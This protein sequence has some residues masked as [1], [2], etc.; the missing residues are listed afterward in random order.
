MRVVRALNNNAVSAVGADGREAVL[1]GPGIGFG[2][3]PG[4]KV[5][6]A[7]AEKVFFINTELQ[8]RL[9]ALL[10]D[11][12]PIHVEVT[13]A[14]VAHA[15][16]RGLSLKDQVLVSLADH[17][18]FAIERL[19]NG[20]HIPFLM[21]SEVRLSYPREFEV[22]EWGR[23]LV[24]ERCHVRLPEDETAYIAL[25]LVN[26]S[27]D[28]PDAY[29]LMQ[30]MTGI[31]RIVE[32]DLGAGLD[33]RDLDAMRLVTHVRFL[34]QRVLGQV[35][36]DDGNVDEL[37]DYLVARNPSH[38]T[39]VGHIRA[40]LSDEYGYQLRNDEEA[41]LLVHLGRIFGTERSSRRDD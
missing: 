32:Q 25:Q 13:E 29:R 41:Y 10:D 5:D 40:Y 8:A 3:K 16:E 9:L 21:L 15:R 11:I 6:E 34:A 26:A 27:L 1:T 38:A 31:L 7:R 36:G 35:Q 33:E 19:R 24:N 2:R 28:Q 39:C 12:D 22:A 30:C 14:I 18:S 17:I 20:T 23:Q 4:D 37:R